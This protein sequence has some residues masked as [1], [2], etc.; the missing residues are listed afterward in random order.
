MTASALCAATNPHPQLVLTVLS[1]SRCRCMQL[2]TRW[3]TVGEYEWNAKQWPTSVKRDV[4]EAVMLEDWEY[5][6]A[7]SPFLKWNSTLRNTPNH[8]RSG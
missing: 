7:I 1:G 3:L 6:T 8:Y 2:T 5:D 4:F